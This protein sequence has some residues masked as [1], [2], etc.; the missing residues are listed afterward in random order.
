MADLS[1][2]FP[3]QHLHLRVL[4]WFLSNW[5][6]LPHPNISCN[7]LLPHGACT[8]YRALY[9]RRRAILHHA[10]DRVGALTSNARA[11]AP[12]AKQRATHPSAGR[13]TGSWKHDGAEAKH[14]SRCAL[15]KKPWLD[16]I[17]PRH[18][19]RKSV[20]RT[21]RSL[22]R[23]SSALPLT[24][25]LIIG[26]LRRWKTHSHTPTHNHTHREGRIVPCSSGV[27]GPAGTRKHMHT[28]R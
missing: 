17:F 6:C 3:K 7:Q 4:T 13:T 8:S 10:C 12:R 15:V 21:Q 9:N 2:R 25:A 24:T 14:K 11:F 26:D 22:K 18:R 19:L 28:D 16:L 1:K 5:V 20:K 27:R 23:S